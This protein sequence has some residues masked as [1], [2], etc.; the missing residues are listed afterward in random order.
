MSGAIDALERIRSLLPRVFSDGLFVAHTKVDRLQRQT[1]RAEVISLL[2]AR[3]VPVRSA[4]ADDV[5]SARLNSRFA[6]DANED[7]RAPSDKVLR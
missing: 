6:L 1:L 3:T 2:G 5:F 7:V 4:Q